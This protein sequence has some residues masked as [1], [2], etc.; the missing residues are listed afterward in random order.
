MIQHSGLV[1]VASL[2]Q[3]QSQKTR[4]PN[5]W[6]WRHELCA[7]EGTS[8]HQLL[9]RP[10]AAKGGKAL[11]FESVGSFHLI[12]LEV[13]RPKIKV[14]RKVLRVAALRDSGHTVLDEVLQ[15]NLNGGLVVRLG[16]ARGE[17]ARHDLRVGALPPRRVAQR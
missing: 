1:V 17:L 13:P 10:V 7:P 4:Q 11:G 2:P 3:K 14:L 12:L 15:S 6:H 5:V 9:L 16:Q 8:D